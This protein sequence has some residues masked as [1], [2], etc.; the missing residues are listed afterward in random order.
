M[1]IYRY[2]YKT[3]YGFDDLIMNGDG[4][5]LTALCFEKSKDISKLCRDCEEKI[6]PIFEDAIRWLD[7]YFGGKVPD[8]TPK[9]KIENL[10]PFRSR[11]IEFIKEIPYGEAVS[12]GDIARKIAALKGIAKMSAQAVGGA[13]GSNPICIIVPCHRVVGLG[14]KLVGYGGGLQNKAGLLRLEGI[15][16]AKV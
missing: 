12:Y 8:F 11:V 6:T 15:D 13:V 16:Y 10:T 4:E 3:P 14:G 2:L 7:M 5:Y 9:Y 1:G